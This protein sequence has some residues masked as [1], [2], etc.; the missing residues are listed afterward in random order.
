MS[1][2]V[3]TIAYALSAPTFPAG[4]AVANVVVSITDTSVTPPVATTQTVADGTTTV[5]FAN[6]AV[7]SYTASAQA[8]DAT[9]AAL[10]PAATTTFT[11]TAPAT[12]ALSLPLTLNITQA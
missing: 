4:S 5:T 8:V 1:N 10:G 9:G 3:A 12:I 7:G 11:I 6:V 2:A